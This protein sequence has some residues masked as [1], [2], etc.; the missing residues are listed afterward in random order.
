MAIFA[1]FAYASGAGVTAVLFLRFVIAAVLMAVI[2]TA[3]GQRWPRGKTLAILAA[4]GAIG[5]VGQ[6][7]CFFTAL[8][9]AS[10]GLVALLL[11]LYPALVTLLSALVLREPLTRMKAVALVLAL[12]G[13]ALTIGPEGGPRPLGI[14]LGVAAAVIYS[15]YIIVGS[16]ATKHTGAIPSSA[17]I[18][19]SAAVVYG[20]LVA[21]QP[22]AFPGTASGWLAVIA[23]AVVS[24]VIAIVAFFAGMRR[25]GAADAATLSTLEPVV[26]VILAAVV[27]GEAI[28]PVQV[29]GGAVIIAA[30]VMLAR[31]G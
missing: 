25:I 14:A 1:R 20:I 18:T 16:R 9:Y 21:A 31:Q 5:Y 28:A 3:T 27:L 30:A 15:V 29:L 23:I 2:M 10:P 7:F 6:S 4:M 26:T 19:A 22:P 24:T 12:A 8:T 17:V 11:Y 13:T